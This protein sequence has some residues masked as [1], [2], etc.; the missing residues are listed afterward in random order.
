MRGIGVVKQVVRALVDQLRE[1]DTAPLANTTGYI[2][3]FPPRE[4]YVSGS[5]QSVMPSL[6]PI[7]WVAVTREFDS[8][9]PDLL[10]DVELFNHQ[11]NPID[12][13]AVPVVW[14]VKTLGTSPDHECVR[15]W[16]GQVFVCGRLCRRCS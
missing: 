8:N 9:S 13:M 7:V 5:S 15:W 4:H 2:Y 6:V 16:N 10:V 1:F 3:R 12:A 11:V 14:V